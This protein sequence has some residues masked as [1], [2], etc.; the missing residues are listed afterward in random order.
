MATAACEGAAQARE[1]LK[2]MNVTKDVR[3]HPRTL[4]TFFKRRMYHVACPQEF[5]K[6]EAA[7]H[8]PE[9][10]ELFSEYVKEISDPKVG[11]HSLQKERAPI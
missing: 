5:A 6:L 11:P 3:F 4:C 8:K 2:D 1:S 9:F 10:M 7:F